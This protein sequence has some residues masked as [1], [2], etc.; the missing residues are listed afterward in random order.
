VPFLS[1]IP[2]FGELFTR[3]KKTLSQSQVI[4]TITPTINKPLNP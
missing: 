3:R 2:I 4:I 1:Q